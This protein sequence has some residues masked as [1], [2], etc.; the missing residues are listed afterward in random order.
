MARHDE[1]RLQQ[2]CKRWFDIQYRPYSCLLFA[3]PNGGGRSRI[4]AS[5]MKGEGVVSGVSD[6]LLLVPNTHYHALCI[7][8]K[9][10]TGRQSLNQKAWQQMVEEVGY[11][12]VVVRSFEQFKEVVDD[13]MQAR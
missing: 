4:E 13:Y 11:M 3:V 10:E 6:M 8:M 2:T 5:I 7:E 12:Y 9:T 1:S